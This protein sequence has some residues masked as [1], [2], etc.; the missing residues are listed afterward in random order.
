MIER[1]AIY[2]VPA[3]AGAVTAAVLLGPGRE[4][5]VVGARVWAL[6]ADGA[7]ASAFRVH[8]VIHYSGAYLSSAQG[9]LELQVERQGRALASWSGETPEGGLV[10]AM[11]RFEAPIAEGAV[12][13]VAQNGSLLAAG[14]IPL[15]PELESL[16]VAPLTEASS[17]I[18][19]RVPR[20]RLAPP[21]PELVE[22]DADTPASEE[23]PKLKAQADGAMVRVMGKPEGRCEGARCRHRWR[24][25]A[26][27]EAPS[28]RLEVAVAHAQ[29]KLEWQGEL[30][31]DNGAMWLDPST[32]L[33]GEVS[34]RAP[35]PH[36]QAFL[37][38]YTAEG[39]VWGAIAPMTTAL[40]GIASARVALPKPKGAATLAVSSDAQAVGTGWPLR[41]ELGVLEPPP[42]V[43]IADGM[44][45]MVA[46]EQARY[47]AARRPAYGLVIAAG[48]FELFFLWRQNRLAKARLEAHLRTT[49]DATTVARVAGN[50]PLMWLSVLALALAL[51]FAVL[52]AVAAWA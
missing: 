3:L 32:A 1:L 22:I 42:L 30:P 7:Q 50:V 24:L 39:R 36:G 29:G 26:I 48:L 13:R 12:V 31:V 4:R 8:T 10:E 21:F 43:R 25:E 27:V 6:T 40:D 19:V 41:P 11:V 15:S 2:G 44:P 35:A 49:E 9:S 37:S 52:A 5:P 46:A 34:V 23:T 28:A 16:P 18:V 47:R 51:A 14:T 45:V 38:L 33:A 20:G 17:S